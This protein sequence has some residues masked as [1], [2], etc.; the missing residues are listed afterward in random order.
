MQVTK[1]YQQT[2][3]STLLLVSRTRVS[4][5]KIN[6]LRRRQE[7][8]NLSKHTDLQS[9]WH[10]PAHT[11]KTN[12]QRHIPWQLLSDTQ[13]F[14]FHLP[15]KAPKT[16]LL[17][18]SLQQQSQESN[19]QSWDLLSLLASECKSLFYTQ[20][21]ERL[22]EQAVS[23]HRISCWNPNE[24]CFF[25]H[26]WF[27]LRE[28]TFLKPRYFL[29][30]LQAVI[31]ISFE[32]GSQMTI[33]SRTQYPVSFMKV[34]LPGRLFTNH[35]PPCCKGHAVSCLITTQSWHA[36]KTEVENPPIRASFLRILGRENGRCGCHN[37]LRERCLYSSL[38]CPTAIFPSVFT[39]R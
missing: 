25:P 10:P 30:H 38:F 28:E 14:E 5:S 35:F 31:V 21:I 13:Y 19:P 22:A 37:K 1:W 27:G 11:R 2:N 34:R 9:I 15:R 36:M 23:S 18:S 20:L 29:Q 7:S 8:S 39:S 33:C 4:L 3:E 17:N 24:F 26:R 16:P 12:R 6:S 32:C